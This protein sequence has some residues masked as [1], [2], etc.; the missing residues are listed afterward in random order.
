MLTGVIYRIA[1]KFF[2]LSRKIASGTTLHFHGMNCLRNAGC[3]LEKRYDLQDRTRCAGE[4]DRLEVV[5]LCDSALYVS[6]TRCSIT[7]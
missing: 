3:T 6:Q 5:S 2:R 4:G 7:S 1:S